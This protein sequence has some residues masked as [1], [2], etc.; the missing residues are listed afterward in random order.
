M[1]NIQAISCAITALRSFPGRWRGQF[2]SIELI[3]KQLVAP[4]IADSVLCKTSDSFTVKRSHV[5]QSLTSFL[6]FTCRPP[7]SNGNIRDILQYIL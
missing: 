3:L 4:I 6:L 2:Y 7:S 1:F 5:R